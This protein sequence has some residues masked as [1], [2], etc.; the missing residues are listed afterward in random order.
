M[1][2]PGIRLAK[3]DSA[4]SSPSPSPKRGKKLPN[5]EDRWSSEP[6][7]NLL[8]LFSARLNSVLSVGSA[9]SVN[10]VSKS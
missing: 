5:R 6:S 3:F 10:G 2:Q 7:D 1:H 8:L 4:A 9:K